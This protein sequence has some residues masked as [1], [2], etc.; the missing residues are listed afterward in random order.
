[1]PFA[2]PSDD[3]IRALLSRRLRV[4][5]VGCS[6]D[7]SRDSHRIARLLID[8][9]HRV[10]P[11]NPR[12]SGELLG[13][14]VYAELREIGEPVDMVD[15]FRRSDQVGPIVNDAVAIGAKV[16][17][18]QLDV[19]DEAAAARAQQAGL[20]VVMDRCPAIEYRRLFAG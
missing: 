8:R 14:P 3:Q 7:P 15:I 10:F 16:I 11:V 6:P 13:L 19:I 12:A 2:N 4:A 1:M 18:M 17:W 20:T 5:V 9:G